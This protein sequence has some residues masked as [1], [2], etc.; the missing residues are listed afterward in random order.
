MTEMREVDHTHPH[1]NTAFGRTFR[2]G[3]VAV[4]ADGGEAGA[5][6]AEDSTEEP[7]MADV[8]HEP[9]NEGASRSFERGTEGRTDTV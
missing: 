4:A 3:G 6:S 7:T 2:H 9:P 1:T 5:G 8:S